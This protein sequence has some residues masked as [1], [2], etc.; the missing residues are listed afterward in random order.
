MPLTHDQDLQTNLTDNA[1][2]SPMERGF[3]PKG[4]FLE[5]TV[6]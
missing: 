3:V 1:N 2:T 5:I 6:G 4:L